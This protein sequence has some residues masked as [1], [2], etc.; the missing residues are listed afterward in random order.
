MKQVI[1]KRNAANPLLLCQGCCISPTLFNIYI[2]KALEEWKRKC[3]RMGITLENTTLYTLQ[4][5]DDQVV[6]AGD[7][8]DLEY[9]TSKL[10]ETYKKWALDMNLN[11][12]KYLCIGETHSNL[13][14]DKDSKIEF[15][16]EYK[17]LGVIFYASRTDDKQ[18]RS[19]VIQAR[20]CIACINGILWNKDI[21]KERKLNIYNALI[22]SSLMYGSE[23]WRLTE[24]NK[25]R[26]KATEM[27]ALRRS[28]RISR[29]ERIRSIT[30]RQQIGLE[31]P[32]IK[33]IEQNQLTWY[34]HVQRMAE[35]RLP[36]TALKWI[37][38][39]KRARE[40]PKK[41]WMEGIRKAINERCLNE[42]KWEDTKQWSLGVRQR[43]TMF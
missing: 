35:G 17:Y 22:K 7:K 9:M 32:L 25:R 3:S 28:S 42:G 33:E 39:Q 31:E 26:V 2:Q 20:K 38:K 23:T 27:D 21:G 15:C 43:R 6:L 10:K 37:L 34:S 24:N 12:T 11:K 18:I 40:R 4:S 36:K 14:L 16:Q 29:K 8:E 41:N 1:E 13:K 5:A 30:I 19:R